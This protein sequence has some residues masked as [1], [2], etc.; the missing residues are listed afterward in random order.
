MPSEHQPAGDSGDRA[1]WRQ[2]LRER[3]G[4]DPAEYLYH[5]TGDHPGSPGMSF[6]E[7]LRVRVRGI[8]RLETIGAWQAAER[9]LAADAGREP[10]QHILDL[11]QDQADRL[12]AHGTRDEHLAD[13]AIP[14][15]EER[16]DPR[17]AAD[18]QRMIED[19]SVGTST[20][21]LERLRDR[22]REAEREDS[23]TADALD[24]IEDEL[25]AATDGGEAE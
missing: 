4:E 2:R 7:W 11:L 18:Y 24:G 9:R 1:D 14:P 12:R 23:P 22:A 6:G 13:A 5:T 3:I 10:R 16:R 8:D 17:T 15:R 19:A 21:G 25:R 20:N